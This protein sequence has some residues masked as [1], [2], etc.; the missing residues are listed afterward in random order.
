V[1]EAFEDSVRKDF[2]QATRYYH[3]SRLEPLPQDE[4]LML[5]EWISILKQKEEKEIYDTLNETFYMTAALRN[6][7]RPSEY[8][9]SMSNSQVRQLRKLQIGPNDMPISTADIHGPQGYIESTI[10]LR[11]WLI[12]D[13]RSPTFINGLE[14]DSEYAFWV[15]CFLKDTDWKNAKEYFHV[16]A[17]DTLTKRMRIRALQNMAWICVHLGAFDDAISSYDQ[18]A[19]LAELQDTRELASE[20]RGYIE[21]LRDYSI[22]E[23]QAEF[24]FAPA[25]AEFAEYG[26]LKQANEILESLQSKG[27]P[28]TTSRET[29]HLQEWIDEVTGRDR[30]IRK[31][32]SQQLGSDVDALPAE[33]VDELADAERLRLRQSEPGQAIAN[34]YQAVA[35]CLQWYIGSRFI[36]YARKKVKGLRPGIKTLA[37]YQWS[38]L[39][40][41]LDEQGDKPTPKSLVGS[42]I[43]PLR[44]FLEDNS[45]WHNRATFLSLGGKLSRIQQIRN[46]YAHREGA[47]AGGPPSRTQQMQDLEEMHTLVVGQR[48]PDSIINQIIRLDMSKKP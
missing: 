9:D 38:S 22:D 24:M 1:N 17:K 23:P 12:A 11:K 47:I 13:A 25:E 46:L 30:E 43:S 7:F 37:V 33:V 36:P 44:S 2:E 42:L 4:S 45:S 15:G 34:L 6:G 18:I 26:V 35:N 39:F 48:D 8:M 27:E 3:D 16:A 19:E 5:E 41:S 14:N 31:R 32:V 20:C 40:C 10:Q 21:A 28:L 29:Y